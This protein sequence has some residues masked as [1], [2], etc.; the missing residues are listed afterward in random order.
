MLEY[1]FEEARTM[2]NDNL[3]KSDEKISKL[4]GDLKHLNTEVAKVEELI[5]KIVDYTVA[6]QKR[7]N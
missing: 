7:Q 1:S 2:L 3:K 6:E 4:D 5:S